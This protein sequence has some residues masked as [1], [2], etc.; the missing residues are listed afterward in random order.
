MKRT[1]FIQLGSCSNSRRG[2]ESPNISCLRPA[3][4]VSSFSVGPASDRGAGLPDG[5]SLCRTAAA[6]KE[7][8][9]GVWGMLALSLSRS[10]CKG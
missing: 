8:G 9:K 7:G 6:S 10:R 3:S 4:L 5:V 1:Y 2:C